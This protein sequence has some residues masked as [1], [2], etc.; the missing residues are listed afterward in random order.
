MK[1]AMQEHIE[2]LKATLEI[3]KENAS[4]LVNCLELCL[5]DAESKLEMEKEQLFL[6]S[7]ISA[8]EAYR[9]GQESMYCGCYEIDG[10]TTYEEW[11]CKKIK[12]E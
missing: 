11:L 4:S 7:N 2:W 9:A 8:V 6:A 12:S 3:C 1:T 10:C 5:K